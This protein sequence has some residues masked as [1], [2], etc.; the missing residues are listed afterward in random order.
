MIRFA[1][2]CEDSKTVSVAF[3]LQSLEHGRV[4]IAVA[5]RATQSTQGFRIERSNAI[6]PDNWLTWEP[7]DNSVYPTI[8]KARTALRQY[9]FANSIR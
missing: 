2:R 7:I 5:L 4:K 9:A 1:T 8:E 3:G 6:A